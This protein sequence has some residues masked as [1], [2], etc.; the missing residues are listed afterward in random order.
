MTGGHSL[1]GIFDGGSLKWGVTHSCNTGA[2]LRHAT[3]WDTSTGVYI[4]VQQIYITIIIIT[5]LM[6]R[7]AWGGGAY[8]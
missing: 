8:K 1:L 4:C 2:W 3:G 5:L 6:T 7:E